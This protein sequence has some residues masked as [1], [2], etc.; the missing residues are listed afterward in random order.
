MIHNFLSQKKNIPFRV[1]RFP[2]FYGWLILIA[3]TIGVLM[4]IPGQT[5][6]VS[7]FTDHLL[8]A[9]HMERTSLSLAY[10]IGTLSSG[11]I[12]TRAGKLY[13]RYGARAMAMVSGF[14]LG[15]MLFALAN[16]DHLISRFVSLI[17][18]ADVQDV[19]F[20]FMVIGF[21]GI[22]FFG[23]G[24][25]TMVSRN[26]VMK[27]FDKRRGLANGIMGVFVSFGFSY[28]PRILNDLIDIMDWRNVWMLLGA[29]VGLLFIVFA[30]VFF[31]DNPH[32][33]GCLPDGNVKQKDKKGKEQDKQHHHTLKEA[34]HTYR[35]WVFNLNL[36][37][38]AL[39][40]TAITFHIVSIFDEAGMDRDTAVSI[41]LPASV[42]AVSCNFIF[43]WLSDYIQ[44]K[45][46]L[47]MNQLGII[48]A[49]Y[50]VLHLG[51]SPL[52]FYLLIIGNGMGS[53]MFSVLSSVTWPRFF[54]TRHL[55]AI[56][57]FAM[58]WVVIGSAFGPFLYS[59]SLKYTE[60]YNTSA[61]I[62]M[63]IASVIFML[64]LKANNR[65]H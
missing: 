8:E 37:L 34:L 38:N 30:F 19:T 49:A 48:I 42:I 41:F 26:M 1:D 35:F 54:G 52:A 62:C 27:W 36:A 63:A 9:L 10:L 15:L 7:V 51:S 61:I 39:F 50:A 58:S 46:L 2:F 6:G 65:T 44:L 47:L 56:S 33:C 17:T 40:V 3:G 22:R 59:L 64:G 20:V 32:D 53:G 13:D 21:F 29:C 57:G 24:I 55:G 31:R 23:Q 12:I 25:L 43:G 60:S 45:Y 4:S 18:M 16:I 28:S 11:L 14:M 5:M